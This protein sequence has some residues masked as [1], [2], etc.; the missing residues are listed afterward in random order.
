M[1]YL[2]IITH[3]LTQATSV[4]LSDC[5]ATSGASYIHSFIFYTTYSI[6]GHRGAGAY[7]QH[8]TGEMQGTPWTGCQSITGQHRDIQDTHS[9]LRAR[10]IN[11]TVMFLDCGRKPEYLDRT[12]TCTGR[13]YKLHAERPPAGRHPGP[14]C[15][16]ATVLSTAPLCSPCFLYFIPNF[17]WFY[18]YIWSP[19]YLTTEKKRELIG[20]WLTRSRTTPQFSDKEESSDPQSGSSSAP[21]NLTQSKFRDN[22]CCFSTSSLCVCTAMRWPSSS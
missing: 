14:S 19:V 9:H 2:N 15:C 16:K 4:V 12:H 20:N 21:L 11:L 22:V 3:W 10:P 17:I 18:R 8:F 5:T 6:E 7:L 1:M 13:T